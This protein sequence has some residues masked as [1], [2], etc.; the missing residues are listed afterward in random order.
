[1]PFSFKNLFGGDKKKAKPRPPR[2]GGTEKGAGFR[3][4]AAGS[5]KARHE[6]IRQGQQP[7]TSE[8]I[9]NWGMLTGSEVEEFLYDAKFL[10]VHSSNVAG[11]QYFFD[12][13]EL[14]VDF[15]DGSSYKY[16]DVTLQEAED[17]TKAQSKGGWVWDVL[18]VRGSDTQHKKKFTRL[19]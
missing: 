19:H 8:E 12:K 10:P 14:V 13:E 15:L 16:Y 3:G 4:V 1:M 5:L 9:A 2:F 18:R 6:A 7:Y 17:F 11:T